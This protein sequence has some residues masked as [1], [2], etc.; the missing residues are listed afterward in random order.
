MAI[1]LELLKERLQQ[2]LT[3]LDRALHERQQGINGDGTAVQL[4]A[5]TAELRQL[6]QT[7]AQNPLPPR[8]ERRLRSAAIVIDS[9]SYQSS[10]GRAVTGFSLL[11]EQ[12]E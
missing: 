11:Y 1:T 10:L 5:M 12:A 7:L 4:Q 6:Q 3:L 8:E 9:W 2:L